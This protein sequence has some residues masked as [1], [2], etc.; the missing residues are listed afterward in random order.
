[1]LAA[2]VVVVILVAGGLNAQNFEYSKK[3][4]KRDATDVM[5]AQYLLIEKIEEN[6]TAVNIQTDFRDLDKEHVG[7]VMSYVLQ[8]MI[9]QCQ[10]IDDLSDHHEGPDS[11]NIPKESFTKWTQN[12]WK[13]Y[14]QIRNKYKD[15]C[16]HSLIKSIEKDGSS[17]RGKPA[18]TTAPNAVM[19]NSITSSEAMTTIRN[20]STKCGFS[21]KIT[22]ILG[23][24]IPAVIILTVS[25]TIY[26][27]LQRR[28]Q[29]V[30]RS[31]QV[32]HKHQPQANM[33]VV[34]RAPS[35]ARGPL[36]REGE[37]TCTEEQSRL[38]KTRI[39]GDQTR[40]KSKE[41]QSD[42]EEED[43]VYDDLY[44]KTPVFPNR[45]NLYN[46]LTDD[47]SFPIENNEE[48]SYSI[49]NK[50]TST[51]QLKKISQQ[52][53]RDASGIERKNNGLGQNKRGGDE[54]SGS[55]N[56][57]YST[58]CKDKK[59]QGLAQRKYPGCQNNQIGPEDTEYD[60]N[61]SFSLT[62][63]Q[64]PAKSQ[65][66]TTEIGYC[67]GEYDTME[68]AK[69]WSDEDCQ[70]NTYNV[71][72]NSYRADISSQDDPENIIGQEDPSRKIRPPKDTPVGKRYS[73]NLVLMNKPASQFTVDE[74]W[75][76]LTVKQF[77]DEKDHYQIPDELKS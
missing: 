69:I 36:S 33:E 19:T 54:E 56:A 53:I 77:D 52:Q 44:L 47:R 40:D 76:E 60:G 37:M 23:F 34:E 59:S 17:D 74:S 43:A 46:T 16:Q 26:L 7:R 5:L 57:V 73:C 42:G 58:I 75:N 28:Y 61:V 4:V 38:D 9:R 6:I 11:C 14:R 71:L 63:S 66:E 51:S 15:C 39:S 21:G 67:K 12:N 18:S 55:D 49:L 64:D 27:L 48:E 41:Q 68:G 50:P 20:D 24:S 70:K 72:N 2:F 3:E 65:Q 29:I 35:E 1:M 62:V 8:Q 13:T 22:T 30:K 45:N 25:V 32:H 10:L 31:I